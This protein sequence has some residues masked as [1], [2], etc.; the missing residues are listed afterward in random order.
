MLDPSIHTAIAS[1]L[2]K[3]INTALQF[4]PASQQQLAK[5]TDILAITFTKPAIKLY[6][7]G[8][9]NGLRV[10]GHYDQAPA[11][12]L[13]GTPRALLSLLKQP[14]NLANSGVELSGSVQTLQQWQS[15]ISQLDIDWEDA[16]SQILGDI[17]GPMA[18]SGIRSSLSWAQR[19]HKSNIQLLKNY[20]TEELKLMPSK[21]ELEE[22]YEK[23]ENLA[24][25]SDRI[26][27]R[28]ARLKKKLTKTGSNTR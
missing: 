20:L 6:F 3:T 28:V 5:L 4:D 19:Q 11:T 7:E 23:V 22:F 9:I 8:T 16:I 25:N 13:K 21:V 27:A 1:A 14:T 15:F 10:M 24:Q 17:A 12:E 18:A 2:E 26:S